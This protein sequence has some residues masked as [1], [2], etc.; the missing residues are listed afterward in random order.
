MDIEKIAALV[1]STEKII[2][3][4]NARESV[5]VKGPADF[6]TMVDTEV[7]SY[8][9]RELNKLYPDIQFMGEEGEKEKID[10]S[11]PVWILDPIDGTTNFI[12]SYPACAVS[13]GLVENG[14]SVL[15]VVFNPALKELLYAQKGKG[16]Y[17]N[18]KRIHVS[19][20]SALSDSLLAIGTSP[21]D[22]TE[23]AE[24]NFSLFHDVFVKC[25]DIRRSGS[26]AFD[27]C[28]VAMGCVDGFFERNLK[29]WDYAAGCVIVQEAGGIVTSMDGGKVT[30]DRNC[31]ILASN[32]KNYKELLDAVSAG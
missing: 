21:Y 18:G 13:L 4:K 1:K 6:V 22:K 11:K 7:Q 14:E 19:D 32:G 2:N 29:P 17:L 27:L 15:G 25:N 24:K 5:T 23:L 3:D 12:Y 16:T 8:L 30:F 26:A 20:T 28:C 9:K 31:N 10:F